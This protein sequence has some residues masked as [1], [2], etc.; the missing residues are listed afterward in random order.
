MLTR[1][2]SVCSWDRVVLAY[3]EVLFTFLFASHRGT[4][5][6][7]RAVAFGLSF[8]LCVE[9]PSNTLRV[10]LLAAGC[11]AAVCVLQASLITLTALDWNDGLN[12]DSSGPFQFVGR[13]REKNQILRGYRIARTVPPH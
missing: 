12:M 3:C 8:Y 4:G 11:P 7:E 6:T 2:R 10:S 5:T 9:S 1:H 13:S